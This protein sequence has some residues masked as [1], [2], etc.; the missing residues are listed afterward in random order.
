MRVFETLDE[1]KAAKGEQLGP[2]DWI[3]ITQEQINGFADATGDHQW[4]H[5]D[6]EKA[7]DGPY[8][9]TIA[10][11]YL[12][13]SHIPI[14]LSEAFQIAGLTMGINYGSNKVRYAAPV[15]VGSKLRGSV[16]LI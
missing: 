10:H 15:P 14:F 8:G 2:S 1:F 4:I 12:V 5:T 13:L 9:T 7:A 11:G 6:P 16:E 3:T